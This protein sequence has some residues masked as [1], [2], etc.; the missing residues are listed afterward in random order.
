MFTEDVG[1]DAT[2]GDPGLGSEDTTE[3][4]GVEKSSGADDLVF[5]ETGELLGKVS[6]DI[7]GVGDD[8]KNGVWAEGLH[9]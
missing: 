6:E 7:D 1:V 9:V 3:T 4:G 8:Q 2:C 5:G